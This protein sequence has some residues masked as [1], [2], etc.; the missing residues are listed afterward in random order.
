MKAP[1]NIIFAGSGAF[2]SPTLQALVDAGHRIVRVYTQPD[3]PAGRGKQLTSTPIAAQSLGMN[4]ELVRT[5]NINAEELP[6]ADAMVVIAF[7]QKIAP[8][9][10]NHTRLKAVNLHASLLPK[11]RGAAPINWAIIRGESVTGNSIIRLAEKMDAGA[12]LEQST[13]PIED[14]VTTGELHDLLAEDG[15]P[16]MLRVLGELQNGTA[17]EIEQDHTLATIA[18]KLSRQTATI[19]WSQPAR[20]VSRLI[21]GLNPWPGCRVQ[22]KDPTGTVL[23]KF[24]ILRARP[25]EGGNVTPGQINAA[26]QIGTGQ[27]LIEVLELQPEGKKPMKLGDYRRGNGWPHGASL[28]S[29]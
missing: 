9:V 1:L 3:R 10:V 28:E 19:D 6:A 21:N 16:L 20:V 12:V 25:V 22:M 15:A 14:T 26:G 23:A 7:G 8:H 2:G 24:S 27:L 13:R 17:H 11:Y 4:L 5:D 18:P 29:F